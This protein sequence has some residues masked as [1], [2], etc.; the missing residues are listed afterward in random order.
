M[1]AT[2]A[3]AA[4]GRRDTS[5]GESGTVHVNVGTN[6]VMRLDDA[7]RA[8]LV[9]ADGAQACVATRVL[10]DGA[11]DTAFGAAGSVHISQCQP[12]TLTLR[13]GGRVLIGDTTQV[14]ALDAAGQ[15]D[16]S[17]GLAGR[18][19]VALPAGL[20]GMSLGALNTDQGDGV[21]A[22]G[23]GRTLS[24]GCCVVVARLDAAGAV[25]PEFGVRSYGMAPSASLNVFVETEMTLA[26]LPTR[27][28]LVAFTLFPPVPSGH[29][30]DFALL[31]LRADASADLD[32]AAFGTRAYD[33]PD[34]SGQGRHA[35]YDQ[36]HG[37][38]L[39]PGMALLLGRTM[40]EDATS[41]SDDSQ[42]IS[43]MRIG[44]ERLFVD[45]FQNP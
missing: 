12:G 41:G 37:A 27:E 36:L 44:F 14:I 39:V 4:D 30:T 1:A 28:V 45:D 2:G 6:A 9:G 19:N 5:Y 33:M 42:P 29:R 7:G 8:V 10:P 11:V 18:V 22:V 23:V 20:T 38:L 16:A 43:V 25:V 32:F 24:G 3:H 17:F 34:L 26:V 35:S 21:W 31:R 13:R 15:L 40:F